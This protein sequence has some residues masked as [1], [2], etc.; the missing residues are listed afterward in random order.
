MNFFENASLRLKQQ[1]GS[2]LDRD[3]AAA[4]NISPRAWAGRKRSGSFPEVQLRAL[5]QRRPDLKID[6][7]YVLTGRTIEQRAMA[8]AERV[9]HRAAEGT[10]GEGI[11]T[12][13]AQEVMDYITRHP[14][15]DPL[16]VAGA[17]ATA[18]AHQQLSHSE[19]VLVRNYRCSAA[20]DREVLRHLAVFFAKRHAKKG[21]QSD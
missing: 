1:L 10:A 8:M 16:Y 11:Y 19:D 15:A 6:V 12:G 4:L 2:S 14:D 13:T 18:E 3:V 9:R 5:A 17:C 21:C 7:D 20:D